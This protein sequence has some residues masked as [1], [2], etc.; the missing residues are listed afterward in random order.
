MTHHGAALRRVTQDDQLVRQLWDDYRTA[1]LAAVDRAL[2]AYAEKLTLRPLEIEEADVE[3]L[4]QA[5]LDDG[6][7]L[8]AAQVAAY[9]N[10]VNRLALGLG[11]EM[12]PYWTEEELAEEIR[13]EVRP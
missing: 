9:F 13:G 2:C 5:G 1:P 8:D 11:V 12:E 4:R 3:T 7:I 10:F 6:Q